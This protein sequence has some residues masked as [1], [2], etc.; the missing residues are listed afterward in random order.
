MSHLIAYEFL[1]LDGRFEGPPDH[2]MDFVTAGFSDR[3]EEDI[4]KQYDQIGSFVMGR[5]TFDGLARYWPTD[6][7]K[8]ERLVDYMNA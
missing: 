7:A 4:A 3:I 8:D 1:S 5:T 6:A 2:E